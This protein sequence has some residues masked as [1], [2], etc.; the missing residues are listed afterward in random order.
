MSMAKAIEPKSNQMNSMD[1]LAGER[2]MT[3]TRVK[4]L[5][6]PDQPVSIWFAEFPEGRPF[7]P[8]KTVNRIFVALWGEDEAAYVGRR[9]T[10]YRDPSVRWAGQ[11]VGGI[12]I[13]AMSHIGN[14]PVSLTLAESQNK[15]AP[16]KVLPLA[17]DAP[18]SPT[19]SEAEVRV[20][21]LRTEWK[22]ADAD[23][24]KAIEAEVA[25]LEAGE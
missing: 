6:T 2:T 19:L 11:E 8:S 4:V 21:E 17:D 14:K 7:K 13:R 18:T 3:I 12:R 25:A 24:R 20:A 22:S 9:L 1:L 15:S 5:D 16:W 10:L 23:R